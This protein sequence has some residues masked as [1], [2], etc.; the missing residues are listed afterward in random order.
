MQHLRC[1]RTSIAQLC[2]IFSITPQATLAQ[3]DREPFG[4]GPGSGQ[5][6]PSDIILG[7]IVFF[8]GFIIYHVIKAF[9]ID[10]EREIQTYKNN[11]RVEKN[12]ENR[13][14]KTDLSTIGGQA[15]S[16]LQNKS[17]KQMLELAAHFGK[18]GQKRNSLLSRQ[19][20]LSKSEREFFEMHKDAVDN[21]AYWIELSRFQLT[22]EGAFMG[23]GSNFEAVERLCSIPSFKKFPKSVHVTLVLLAMSDASK[24][25]TENIDWI[26]FAKEVL[27][28]NQP[29]H[30]YKEFL[31][32]IE[33]SN[34]SIID[35]YFATVIR[36]II[37]CAEATTL[38][39]YISKL[40]DELIESKELSNIS[41]YRTAIFNLL[42]E[43]DKLPVN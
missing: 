18:L 14:R 21:F 42:R 23:V 17:G 12:V 41:P 33:T 27:S 2:I 10:F 19:N 43:M 9:F 3:V 20:T 31:G 25:Y 39:H 30:Y 1:L 38:K 13:H 28:N 6:D 29:Q 32:Q 40:K 4:G 37:F 34:M 15:S 26:G 35:M 8:V 36:K 7:L 22:K 16:A 5:G 11:K 24:H